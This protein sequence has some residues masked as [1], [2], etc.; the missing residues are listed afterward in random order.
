MHTVVRP[1]RLGL[2]IARCDRASDFVGPPALVQ[3]SEASGLFLATE[4]RMVIGH[5]P[6]SS[7]RLIDISNYLKVMTRNSSGYY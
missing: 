4:L 2:A 1:W 6:R 5:S 3:F 7:Y